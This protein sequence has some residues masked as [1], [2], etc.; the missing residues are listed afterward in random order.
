MLR[1]GHGAPGGNQEHGLGASVLPRDGPDT[2]VHGGAT[3]EPDGD[4][5]DGTEWKGGTVYT[6]FK[7]FSLATVVCFYTTHPRR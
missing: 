5:A 6:I 2:R 4:S 3:A 1:G 7:I